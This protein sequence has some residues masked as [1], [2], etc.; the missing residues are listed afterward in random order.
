MIGAED[1]GAKSPKTRVFRARIARSDEPQSYHEPMKCGNIIWGCW[2]WP[3]RAG[4]L[5]L[6]GAH[7]QYFAC[8]EYCGPL[9]LVAALQAYKAQRSQS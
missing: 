5:E 7:I 9:V 6:S 8:H 4:G 3:Q 1:E 2:I